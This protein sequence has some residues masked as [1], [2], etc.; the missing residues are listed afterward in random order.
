MLLGAFKLSGDRL[1]ISCQQSAIDF[2]KKFTEETT[3]P[4]ALF[5]GGGKGFI[6]SDGAADNEAL[7]KLFRD[8]DLAST[9]RGPRG[10]RLDG[11]F[12][13]RRRGADL[14]IRL[15]PP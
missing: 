10:N 15:L 3:F 4:E 1:V 5:D 11:Q 8:E 6:N 2:A 13:G 12:L 9:G 14:S 7:K